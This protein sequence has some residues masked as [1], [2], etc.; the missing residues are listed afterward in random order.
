MSSDDASPSE[1]TESDAAGQPA[2]ALSGIQQLRDRRGS[3]Q[4]TFNDV[5][6][7]LVDFAER[8]PHLRPD[9]DS[10]ASFLAAEL[11]PHQHHGGGSNLN[12]RGR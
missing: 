9:V 4:V 6:D 12:E 3:E 2:A 1:R 5:A 8:H 7:H 10:L 11:H